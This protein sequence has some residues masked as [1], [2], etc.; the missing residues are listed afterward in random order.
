MCDFYL[1]FLDLDFIKK[2]LKILFLKL[3]TRNWKP[4]IL[5]LKFE[6]LRLEF[7]DWNL[8]H[9]IWDLKFETLKFWKFVT[10]TFENEIWGL[11][12]LQL[13]ILETEGLDLKIGHWEGGIFKLGKENLELKIW[14]LEFEKKL[15]ILNLKF[16]QKF[17]P[18]I[19]I[20]SFFENLIFFYFSLLLPL[21]FLI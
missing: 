20:L 10:W 18:K 15:K 13:E 2:T 21:F 19:F 9:G 16:Y 3:E 14:D 7:L 17:I 1:S 5:K 6:I 4:E 11:K 12:F 8:E